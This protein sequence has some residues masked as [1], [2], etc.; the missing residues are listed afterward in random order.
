VASIGYGSQGHAH[1]NN[2]NDSGVEVVIGLRRDGAS[3][4]KAEKA[5]LSV[6]EVSDAVKD[7]EVVMLLL[8]DEKMASIYQTEIEPSLRKNAS[9]AFAHGF[10]IHYGQIVPRDD[11]D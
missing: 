4:E 10:N 8:P 6:K 1:A 9:L 2:L 5:G 3:W 11:L 7:A